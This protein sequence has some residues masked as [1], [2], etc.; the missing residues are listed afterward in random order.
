MTRHVLRLAIAATALAA[1][2]AA[3]SPA[4]GAEHALSLD[5]AIGM[6]LQRNDDIRIDRESAGAAAATVTAAN[7]AYDPTVELDGSWLRSTRPVTY[8]GAGGVPTLVAPEDRTTDVTLL[9]RQFLPTGGAITARAG[10]SRASTDDAFSLLSPEYDTR[11]GLE[12]RQPILRDRATDASRTA[13]RVAA[14]GRTGATA[15]LRTTLEQTVASVERAYWTLVAARRDVLVQ[16]ES[17]RLAEEQLG[18]TQSRVST[19]AAPRTELAQPRAELERRRGEM[20]A[21]GEA[22]ARAENALKVLVLDGEADPLWADSLAPADRAE[23]TTD[24]VD[25]GDAVHEAL[26]NRPE[27]AVAQAIVTRRHAETALAKDGIWPRLD[28]VLSYDRYGLAGD[29]NAAAPAGS[30]PPG[31]EGGL[32]DAFGSIGDGEYDAAR[33]ALVLGLPLGNREARGNAAAARHVERQA[34][35]ALVRLRKTIRAEV[36][37]A[38]AGLDAARQRIEAARSAREAAEVQL[39]AER[40]R[41]ATGLST[42][43]LVL[44]RQ[45]DLSRA[46]LEEI[47]ALTDYRTARTEMARATGTLLERHHIDV[48]P[49]AR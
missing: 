35:V 1:M 24:S 21:A 43:F 22:S 40:D 31:L 49:P 28:V 46:R 45:N 9:V 13:I 36:L 33:V 18:E 15:S 42:N 27:L 10:G 5:D 12:L 7:G 30:L 16:R 38:A 4:V 44:T 8:L 3:A 29:R 39:D 47:S 25:V 14:A 34:E 11:V 19:G 26:Q 17:V 41:Y 2:A 32:G 20:L 23:T 48:G 37:D 6:A